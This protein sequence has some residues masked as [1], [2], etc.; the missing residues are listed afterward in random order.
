MSIVLLQGYASWQRSCKLFIIRTARW[1]EPQILCGRL[2]CA[3]GRGGHLKETW[4]AFVM[5]WLA[6]VGFLDRTRNLNFEFNE[7]AERGELAQILYRDS[8][9]AQSLP[10]CGACVTAE[11]WVM[12]SAVGQL[13]TQPWI[14]LS[15]IR[16]LR[17]L[18]STQEKKALVSLRVAD[19]DLA[20]ALEL[21]LALCQVSCTMTC[22]SFV[23]DTYRPSRVHQDDWVVFVDSYY[24]GALLP[25]KI[26]PAI[27][28]MPATIRN[29][30]FVMSITS[31]I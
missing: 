30:Y 13:G 29:D 1:V 21:A 31:K 28:W 18:E 7:S 24:A 5:V 23:W 10:P 17:S 16:S 4:W 25:D 11:N 14:S 20:K 19:T 6:P 2:G 26:P 8:T 27:Q 3:N 9:S 22:V 15:G 12:R